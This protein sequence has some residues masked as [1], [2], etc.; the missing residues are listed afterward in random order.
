MIAYRRVDIEEMK[1]CRPGF[2]SFS[3]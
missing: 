3:E 2:P 1:V